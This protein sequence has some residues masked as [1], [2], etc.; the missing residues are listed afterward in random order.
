MRVAAH[1]AEGLLATGA[2]LSF[3][4]L[5][6]LGSGV[7]PKIL[8]LIPITWILAHSASVAT[9]LTLHTRWSV[10]PHSRC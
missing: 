6:H 5:Q 8:W 4:I 7:Q 10:G 9:L 3:L 1:L 2:F